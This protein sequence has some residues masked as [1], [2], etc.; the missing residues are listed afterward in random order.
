MS[1]IWMNLKLKENMFVQKSSLKWDREGDT[2]SRY[3]HCV[4]KERCQRN[5]IGSI[6]T[7]HCVLESV[8]EVK[9][10]VRRH[11]FEKFK[12]SN[13][14]RPLLERVSFSV[15]SREERNSL[16]VLFSY[17]EIKEAVWGCKGSKSPGPDGYN[18]F[19]IRM[20]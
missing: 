1:W 7:N 2:N 5:F 18:F 11:F 10:E 17:L 8:G 15:V 4:M 9:K 3:F 13:F 20:C 6:V 12:E 16:K 14:N 19:F